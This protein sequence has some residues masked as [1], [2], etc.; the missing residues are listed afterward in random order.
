MVWNFILLIGRIIDRKKTEDFIENVKRKFDSPF[1]IPE[2]GTNEL[3]LNG[4]AEIHNYIPKHYNLIT[5]CF[6]TGGTLAGINKR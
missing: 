6:G 5:A 1:I 4:T 3:A 2:G